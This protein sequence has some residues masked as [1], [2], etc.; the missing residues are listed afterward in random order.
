MRQSGAKLPVDQ[1]DV[2]PHISVCKRNVHTGNMNFTI[3][4][5]G[6]HKYADQQHHLII[7]FKSISTSN[8]IIACTFLSVIY[9]IYIVIYIIRKW[10]SFSIGSEIL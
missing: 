7:Y 5:A 1:S 10:S 9:N 2:V 6:V 8:I 4:C 3:T